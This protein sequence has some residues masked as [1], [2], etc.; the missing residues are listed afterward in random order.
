MAW[1]FPKD[2]AVVAD[3]RDQA[4]RVE[5][6]IVFGVEHTEAA[7]GEI[8]PEIE[9]EFGCGPDHRDDIRG[10]GSPPDFQHFLYLY[11]RS[12]LNLG[13]TSLANRAQ[14]ARMFS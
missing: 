12:R 6:F 9:A 8:E 2:E 4:V 13:I 11:A 10:V 3:R 14:L 5:F 7:A 1:D